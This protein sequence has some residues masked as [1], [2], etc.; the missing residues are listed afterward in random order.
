MSMS[1]ENKW[2]YCVQ[3]KCSSIITLMTVTYKEQLF[4]LESL[5]T[6]MAMT[7]DSV[8]SAVHVTQGGINW[9]SKFAKT[10]FFFLHF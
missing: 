10:F 8:K 3:L 4:D 1:V 5:F 7:T 6:L 2:Y 9:A